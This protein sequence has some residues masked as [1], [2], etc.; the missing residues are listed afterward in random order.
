MGEDKDKIGSDI[1]RSVATFANLQELWNK[2]SRPIRL[3][4]VEDDPQD[5]YLISRTLE[6]P[7]I[8]LTVAIS[9]EDAKKKIESSRF[10][11]CLI[12]LKLPD[13]NGDD[14]I[15]WAKE[16]GIRTP[17]VALTGIGDESPIIVRALNSGAASVIRKPLCKDKVKLIFGGA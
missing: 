4:I 2:L 9:G 13:I 10:D 17:F 5:I 1:H 6:S 14:V 12:D 15:K 3:L 11:I 16:K 8:E 7:R